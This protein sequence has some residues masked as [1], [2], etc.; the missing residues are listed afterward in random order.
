MRPLKPDLRSRLPGKFEDLSS[1]LPPV[2]IRSELEHHH[3]VEMI[4]RLM[5]SGRLTKGQ[6]RYMETQ[7]QLVQA[8]EASRHA[9]KPSS[10]IE[11]LRQ[12]L[13]EH[14]MSAASL[15]KL[16]GVHVS[17]G[18]KILNGDRALTVDHIR[19]LASAFKVRAEVFLAA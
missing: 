2:A 3:A 13:L 4:D 12:L 9:I 1:L 14:G 11:A 10:G 6:E 17:M 19:T 15:A 7:V 16:L 5:A 18:S 8:Y